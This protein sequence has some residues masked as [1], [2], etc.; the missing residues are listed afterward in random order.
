MSGGG[1]EGRTVVVTREADAAAP[2]AKRLEELGARAVVLPCLVRSAVADGPTALRLRAAVEQADWLV[3]TSRRGVEAAAQ[4]LGEVPAA[5]VRIA[6]V[7]P[8]TAREAESRWGR[9]DLVAPEPTARGL[10]R[11]LAARLGDA[12]ASVRVVVAAATGG[13]DDV[14]RVVGKTGAQVERIAVYRT[15][16]AHAEAEKRDLGAEGVSDVLLASPS[17]VTGLLNR[18]VVPRAV[19]VITIGP[20]TSAAARAAGLA[21]AAEARRPDLEGMLEALR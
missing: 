19:R 14:E 1:L 2:W 3:V 21:V 6:A 15:T 12:A 17:A 13:R 9:V 11:E 20:T 8:E 7:G 16:P 18:A 5:S 10:G 4:L